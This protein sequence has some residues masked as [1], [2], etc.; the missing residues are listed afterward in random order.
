M[1][2]YQK[3]L[4]D[5][6]DAWS[7]AQSCYV[8]YTVPIGCMMPDQQLDAFVTE[9][10]TCPFPGLCMF[11]DTAAMKI[12]SGLISSDSALGINAEPSNRINY[13]RV[14][15][16]APLN[17]TGYKVLVNATQGSGFPVGNLIE[18]IDLGPNQDLELGNVTFDY[19]TVVA[20]ETFLGYQ[21]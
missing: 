10:A 3:V 5:M 14:T 19:D 20:N 11:G 12:D 2:V 6:D 9:N 16:C 18:D 21:L 17:T 8:D 1:T 13:H 15:T 7:Y 4:S